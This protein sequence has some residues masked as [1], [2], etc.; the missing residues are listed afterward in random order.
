MP[1]FHVLITGGGIGGPCLAQGLRK[2]DISCAVYDRD[3]TVLTSGYRLHM[4]GDGGQA[5]QQCLPEP[6]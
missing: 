6:L 1:S 2:D 4:N 3:P 5:L